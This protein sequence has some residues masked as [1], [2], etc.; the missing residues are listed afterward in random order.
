MVTQPMF[1]GAD[2]DT[3]KLQDCIL[4][5]YDSMVNDPRQ[6]ASNCDCSVSYVKETLNDHRPNWNDDSGFL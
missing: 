5:Q 4:R 3:T 1:G 2:D 6:I